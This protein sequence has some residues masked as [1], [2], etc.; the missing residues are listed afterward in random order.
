MPV[1]IREARKVNK[2]EFERVLNKYFYSTKP[3]IDE[4]VKS[5]ELPIGEMVVAKILK[6]ALSSGDIWRFGFIIDRLIGKPKE[7][8]DPDPDTE[9]DVTPS[10]SPAMMTF[11]EFC[12][13]CNYFEPF[14]KQL[15]MVDFGFSE[16]CIR[17]LLGARGYGK[18]DFVTIMGVAYELY[19]CWFL[20]LDPSECTF[21]I[22]TKSRER[23]KAI[24]NEI[25]T[26]LEKVGVP[27]EKANSS[28]IRLK[29]LTGQDHSVEAITIRSTMRGRHPKMIVM[30]D[31]VTDEDVS[32]ATR[33]NVQT[34]YN[35]AAKLT[36]NI[37]IIGQ[38]AH[39]DDLYAKLRKIVKTMT[40]PWGQIPELDI[41]LEALELAGI[42]KDTIEMSYHLQV[43]ETG[44]AIFANIKYTDHFPVGDAIAF[45]DPSEG[46]DYTATSAIKGYL[47]GVAVKGKVWKKAWYHCLDDM[48][49]LYIACGVKKVFFETNTTGDH[50][51]KDLR[52]FFGPHGIGVVGVRSDTNKHA[53]IQS[54]GSY[55][56]LIHLSKDSD[57]I[58]TDQVIKYEYGVDHDDAPDSLARGLERLGLLRGKR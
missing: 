56:H 4:V 30:D 42:D 44:S 11:K 40:V 8:R 12:I 54:A 50:A 41:D 25:T 22:I 27:L 48:L 10:A 24:L 28:I 18:T 17:L 26:A 29:G 47:A 5:K 51:L 58:Y 3:E 45:I 15:E 2:I 39:F 53:I 14:E 57:K 13:A 16:P 49:K 35:E 20:K 21:I 55:S 33:K 43:P 32:P 7:N 38:P 1:D 6:N 19:K 36:Q 9:K 37:L 23:N 31:P 52:A 46:G 34:R